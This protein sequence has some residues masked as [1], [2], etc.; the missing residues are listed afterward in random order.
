MFKVFWHI[1]SWLFDKIKLK[2][3]VFCLN[4]F[5]YFVL[6]CRL[7][8]IDL[9]VL[10]FLSTE[11]LIRPIVLFVCF[12]CHPAFFPFDFLCYFEWQ[13]VGDLQLF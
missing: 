4:L 11:F 9:V 3:R 13:R 2:Y 1:E 8:M 6:F 12:H 7:R 10:E 5:A